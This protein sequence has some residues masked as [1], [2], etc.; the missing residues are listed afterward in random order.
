MRNGISSGEFVVVAVAI[1]AAVVQHFF[2]PGQP[3]PVNAFITLAV[4]VGARFAEKVLGPADTVGK[5]FWQTTE[6]WIA[7]GVTIAEAFFSTFIPPGLTEL[8][9][10]YIGGRP[11]VKGTSGFQLG[12]PVSPPTAVPPPGTT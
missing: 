6:F 5:R 2:A 10:V 9:W 11:V 1:L 3:F 7:I 8:S 4:W 12:A